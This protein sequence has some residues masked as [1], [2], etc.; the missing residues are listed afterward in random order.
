[1]DSRL[2]DFRKGVLRNEGANNTN[3]ASSVILEKEFM[4]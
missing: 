4:V 1:M 2:E 3:A